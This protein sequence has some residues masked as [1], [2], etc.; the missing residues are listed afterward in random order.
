MDVWWAKYVGKEF[1]E[2]GRGPDSYDCWGMVQLIYRQEKA[3]ELPSYLEHYDS[4]E[5]REI[6]GQTIFRER[7]EHWSEVRKPQMFDA[8]LLR[9]RGVPMHVGIVTKPGYMVHCAHGINTVHE[10]FDSMRWA[11]K[12]QGFFRYE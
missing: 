1:S 8:V 7:Q 3:V 4:T 11:D 5:D 2:R 9:M 6:I 12:I 10:R